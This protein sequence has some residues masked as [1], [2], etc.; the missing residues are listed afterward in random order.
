[1]P[2]SAAWNGKAFKPYRALKESW[3]EVDGLLGLDDLLKRAGTPS[4]VAANR[5]S[6]EQLS[7]SEMTGF[8]A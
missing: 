5:P 7:C 8:Q 3:M 1:M 4:G 6:N 2:V